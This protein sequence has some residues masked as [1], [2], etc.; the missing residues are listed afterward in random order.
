MG[1]TIPAA[2]LGRLRK[3]NL[4]MGLLHLAQGIAMLLLSSGFALPVTTSFLEF[5]PAA[6][7]LE[8]VTET[9]FDLRIGPLVA[10]FLFLSAIAHFCLAAPGINGWYNRNLQKGVNYAR[11]M[12]YALSSSVMI[13]VIV[14]L[15]GMYDAVSLMLIFSLNATMILFG[16]MMERHN[17]T[18]QKADW[19]SYWFGCLAGAVPWVAVALYL[20]GSG[21]EGGGPPAFVYWIFF[22]IF[23]FFNVFAVNMALQYKKVGPWRDYVFGERMYIV[24]S[25]VAKSLLAWQVWAGT[26]RPV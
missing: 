3:L 15:T 13:V 26:L 21:G 16:W 8:P 1:Q 25:L 10:L 7:R 17:Q 5:D 23:I 20:F 18:T 19:T 11:W 14:M 2:T 24:L 22:S 6:G 12:E 9:L 4:A